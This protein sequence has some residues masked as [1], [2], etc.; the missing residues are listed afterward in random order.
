MEN[1]EVWW[2]SQDLSV[3]NMETYLRSS[4]MWAIIEIQEKGWYSS[5]VSRLIKETL[6]GN[7]PQ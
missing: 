7:L 4:I 6:E 2:Q 3:G 5:K 1:G